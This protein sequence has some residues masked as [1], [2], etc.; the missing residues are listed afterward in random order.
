ML[1][2]IVN[3][4]NCKAVVHYPR[5]MRKPSK[6][7]H[8]K[9]WNDVEAKWESE[10]QKF[11]YSTLR[12]WIIQRNN[13][14]NVSDELTGARAAAADKALLM[15][16]HSQDAKLHVLCRRVVEHF[17]QFLSLLPKKESRQFEYAHKVIGPMLM[18]CKEYKDAINQTCN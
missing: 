14:Y 13:A 15:L 8:V 3:E 10:T 9:N 7:I 11:I 1:Q 6:E 4:E 12:S 17:Q 5:E 18:W 2:L 16:I